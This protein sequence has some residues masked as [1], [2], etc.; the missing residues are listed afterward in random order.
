MMAKAR[1]FDAVTLAK[2]ENG[3]PVLC[4]KHTVVHCHFDPANEAVGG[5]SSEHRKVRSGWYQKVLQLAAPSSN[6]HRRGLNSGGPCRP[7]TRSHDDLERE[8]L[9]GSFMK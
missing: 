7:P 9:H 5:G 3:F 6:V 4:I 2:L 1:D 8:N